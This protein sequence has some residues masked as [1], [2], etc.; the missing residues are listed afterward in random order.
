ML[1]VTF[2]TMPSLKIAFLYLADV[3]V[4]MLNKRSLV[5]MVHGRNYLKT[6]HVMEVMLMILIKS[7]KIFCTSLCRCQEVSMVGCNLYDT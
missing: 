4:L 1:T 3:Q 5:K 2:L 7:G 6:L